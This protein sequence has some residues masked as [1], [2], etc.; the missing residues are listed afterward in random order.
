MYQ[1]ERG[2]KREIRLDSPY[3]GDKSTRAKKQETR[4]VWSKGSKGQA[5]GDRIT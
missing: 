1:V 3:L 5:G 4:I 2:E